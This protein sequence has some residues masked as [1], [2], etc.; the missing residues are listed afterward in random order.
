MRHQENRISISNSGSTASQRLQRGRQLA[1]RRLQKT[2]RRKAVKKRLVR[3]SLVA[4]NFLLLSAVLV[5]VVTSAH[6][7]TVATVSSQTSAETAAVS[8]VD[9]LTS[10]DVAANIAHTVNLPEKTPITNQAQ[11]ARVAVVVSA[12]DTSVAAKPQV[13]T[14]G[15]KSWRDI[16]DYT[17]AA[18]DNVSTIAQK[19]GVTSES[20]RWS[21]GLSNDNVTAGLKL[22]VPPVSGIVY[23]VKTGDTPQSVATAYHATAEKI[24]QMNDAEQTGLVV[25]KRIIIPDG[26]IIP[27][28]TR[29]YT[30]A[31]S[32]YAA[33]FSPRY[34]ANGYDFG[35][36][37]YYAAA[38]SGA[39]GNWGN[40]N[41]W[42]Y[43]ARISG[44]R[45]SSVPTAGAIF[46]T[47][48]GWAGHVGIVEEVYENGTMKVSDMNG[49]AGFGR[50]GYAVVSVSA[51]PNYITRN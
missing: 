37:T 47:S 33:S 35:W 24:A 19:F 31:T 15:Q 14:A 42:A 12:S 45:V 17:V 13:V 1:S 25:G 11:S 49:F 26:K 22:V 5:F 6:S 3:F 29:T 50:V 18:G 16:T 10:F 36:C 41:T 32:V 2:L 34:G 48:S 20:I 8:P 30:N 46:Q 51:Y 27:V 38:R 39:P 4:A 40:A 21:N 44:W 23:T 28:A 7:D 9:R 43:Y